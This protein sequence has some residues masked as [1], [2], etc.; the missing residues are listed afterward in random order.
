MFKIWA[1]IIDEDRNIVK[2]MIYKND[3]Q[4]NINYF[5]DYIVDIS[6]ELK[7]STPN[8]LTYHKKNYEEF[9][10]VKFSASDFVEAVDFYALILENGE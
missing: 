4:F 2:D 1:K 9:M 6:D 10:Y 8:I 3:G 7:I 5:F